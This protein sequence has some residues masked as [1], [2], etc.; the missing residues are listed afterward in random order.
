MKVTACSFHHGLRTGRRFLITQRSF[1]YRSEHTP[2]EKLIFFSRSMDKWKV[3]IFLARWK[4]LLLV[5]YFFFFWAKPLSFWE[6]LTIFAPTGRVRLLAILL[7]SRNHYTT[8]ELLL[9][10]M[11]LQNCSFY[12]HLLFDRTDSCLRSNWLWF[13]SNWSC[14]SHGKQLSL[15][16]AKF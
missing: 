8:Q 12:N 3:N 2:L 13:R 6:K 4:K 5:S 9:L 11:R 7:R 14:K 1:V 15:S 10:S 16:S